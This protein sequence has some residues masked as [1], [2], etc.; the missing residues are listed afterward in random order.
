MKDNAFDIFVGDHVFPNADELFSLDIAP[1]EAVRDKCDVVVDTSVLLL[2][3]ETSTN[4]LKEIQ[5]IY[6]TL[7]RG[8]RLFVPAQVAREFARL[9]ARKLSEVFQALTEKSS[10]VQGHSIGPY[11]LLESLSEYSEVLDIEKQLG[12]QVKAYRAALKKLLD[13]I[14]K[15]GWNDPVATMYRTIF[16]SDTIRAHSFSKHDVETELA[17][18]TTNKIPPGYKDAT[19]DDRGVGDLLIWLTI[20]EIGA[21]RK[22]PLLF[23]TGEEKPD[24]Q[25]RSG[26]Q[27]LL[28]RCEL[29]DEFRRKSSGNSFYIAP[30]S[31]LL[32]LFQAPREIVSAVRKQEE[33]LELRASSTSS[34]SATI[35]LIESFDKLRTLATTS[36]RTTIRRSWELLAKAIFRYTNT[37]A[38]NLEPISAVMSVALVKLEADRQFS[39]ESFRSIADLQEAARKVFYQSEFAYAPSP[40][41]ADDFVVRSATIRAELGEEVE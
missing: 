29:V 11:P 20:I 21:E 10:Q 7:K 8:G 16:S 39:S 13:A 18:R 34:A 32:E 37:P 17:Y 35:S 19:K 24:W 38:E 25:Y 28:P 40:I 36:P 12:Q 2:P 1:L 5:A 30:F 14:R 27:G 4:S 6:Q 23:V 9:R 26:K 41:E 22:K 15:W 31:G 33:T 3:Y